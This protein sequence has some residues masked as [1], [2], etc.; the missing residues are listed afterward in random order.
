MKS[1]PSFDTIIVL[2]NSDLSSVK[3]LDSLIKHPSVN[4]ILICDNSD[5]GQNHLVML[6][7]LD[8]IKTFNMH[9]NAGISRAYNF[10]ISKCSADYVLI[11]DDDTELSS[12][13]FSKVSD[14]IRQEDFDVYMPLVWS[15]S[16]LMSPCRKKGRRFVALDD[17]LNFENMTVSGI[18][19]GLVIKRSVFN[20]VAYR[21][22]LFLDMVDHAFFDD[23]RAQQFRIKVMTDV[24]LLQDYSRETDNF[25]TAKSR[26]G[27]SKLDN[28]V[29]FGSCFSDRLFCEAQL[30]YW[31]LKKAIKFKRL[32]VLA[33]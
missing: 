8:C 28:R 11:L 22:E 10:A 33:W 20:S 25:E 4:Q 31:K 17:H 24:S 26:F 27:I 9:G 2:Y 16:I 3:S 1:N 21:E 29:Y 23:V 18:N 7:D 12:D 6:D 32:S 5:D 19:S 14:H 13:F 15:E 30:F